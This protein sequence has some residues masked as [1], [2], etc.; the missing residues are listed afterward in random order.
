MFWIIIIALTLVSLAFLLPPLLR[1]TAQLEDDRHEQNI[2][3]AKRQLAELESEF[4]EGKIEEIA[5]KASREELE[6]ALYDDLQTEETH[7]T[8]KY[9]FVL[10]QKNTAIVLAIFVPVLAFALYFSLGQPNALLESSVQAGSGALSDKQQKQLA[11]I[12]KMVGTLEAKLKAEP[13][14][15]EG[16]V[17]LGRTYMVL[18]RYAEA[19]TAYGSANKLQPNNPATLLSMADALAASEQGK[20]VG[21]AEALIKQALQVDANHMM[22][23]WLAGLAAKQ[24]GANPEALAHWQKLEAMLKPDSEDHKAIANL[25]RSVGGTP[26]VATNA[27]VS[28][29]TSAATTTNAVASAPATTSEP[30]PQA[31]VAPPVQA[32]ATIAPLAP[33][34]APTAPSTT[35]AANNAVPTPSTQPAANNVA[36]APSTPLAT[37][38]AAT[39]QAIV[40]KVSL[41]DALKAQVKPDDLIF[42]YAK[43]LRGPPMPLAAARK[44]VKDLPLEITL[45]DSMAMMPQ[46]RL[47]A[48]S[49]VKVGARISLTG[50]PQAQVGDLF[51]EKSPVQK[52]ESIILEINQVVAN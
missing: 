14:N 24:R 38:N 8:Q 52:G 27:T 13:N 43:A 48:F 5:Y 39:A 36:S 23:L 31:V 18:K 2:T 34:I 46:M 35:P 51:T 26:A 22:G 45:D 25:I 20:L 1:K 11:S 40:V 42:I 50:T 28:A 44:Q 32:N 21:K 29:P 9:R 7:S 4:K 49:E 37:N 15:H 12:D 33:P 47:S 30:A 6:Q 3:I 19:A 10:N 16:W 17:M 41:S